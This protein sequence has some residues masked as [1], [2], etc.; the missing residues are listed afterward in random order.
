M[1]SDPGVDMYVDPG[2]MCEDEYE[3]RIRVVVG[4]R[5][6]LLN[7]DPHKA[8]AVDVGGGGGWAKCVSSGRT[9]AMFARVGTGPHHT[10]HLPRVI[11]CQGCQAKGEWFFMSIASQPRLLG[12]QYI[13]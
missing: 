5:A 2:R 13:C 12:L 6:R 4:G 3:A 9:K 1:T 7:L 10:T 8:G 11:P